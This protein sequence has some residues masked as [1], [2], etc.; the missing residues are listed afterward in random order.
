MT[1]SV[2]KSVLPDSMIFNAKIAAIFVHE[3]F[4]KQFR[5]KTEISLIDIPLV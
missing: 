3:F 2:Y 1:N 5:I 4:Q